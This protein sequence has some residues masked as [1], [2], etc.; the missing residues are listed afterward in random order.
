MIKIG[1]AG[2]G[3]FGKNHARIL[4]KSEFCNLIGI[5]DKDP[6]QL[7]KT[8]SELQV[9]AFDSY[10]IL[11]SQVEAVVIVVTTS[12]HYEMAKMALEK[13]C[14]HLLKN[15]SHRNYGRR[16]NSLIWLKSRI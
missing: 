3:Q 2:V 8:A 5:Y 14:I 12:F 11:L 10:E 13:E 6:A 7:K 4:E 15:R 1:V 9:K 16:K